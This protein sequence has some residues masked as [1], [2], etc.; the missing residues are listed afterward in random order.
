MDE[1]QKYSD[2]FTATSPRFSLSSGNDNGLGDGRG[3][4]SALSTSLANQTD[5]DK[6]IEEFI[7]ILEEHREECV[8]NGRYEDAEEAQTRLTEL[9]DDQKKRKVDMVRTRHI[10]E[11]LDV[12]EAHMREFQQFNDRWNEKMREFDERTA[13]LEEAMKEKHA[14]E[15][16]AWQ[17][18]IQHQFMLRP[19][20]SRDLLNLRSIED[21]LAKQK[22]YSEAQR[23]KMKADVMEQ[24]ELEHLKKGWRQKFLQKQANFVAKQIQERDAFKKRIEAG[25]IKQQRARHEKLCT[26]VQRYN[27]IKM[28]LARQQNLEALVENNGVAGA[29]ARS[30][31]GSSTSRA[32]TGRPTP[33][34]KM[35]MNPRVDYMPNRTAPSTAPAN[36]H[37]PAAP[38]LSPLGGNGSEE[39]HTPQYTDIMSTHKTRTRNLDSYEV[40]KA[41][42]RH[43]AISQGGL[44][45]PDIRERVKSKGS[46]IR[47]SR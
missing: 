19:K 30:I 6:A 21:S 37:R 16:A 26:V 28:G 32:S 2:S 33:R 34:S 29:K 20:L 44:Q 23:V 15:L 3:T 1:E 4:T 46:R 17:E 36:A 14:E 9:K 7:A 45:Q 25:R 43:N 39:E 40:R 13:L 42:E 8:H 11:R 47:T 35:Y 5:D 38:H 10:S 12:E 41:H 27:N 22:K 18:A 31:S 24:W